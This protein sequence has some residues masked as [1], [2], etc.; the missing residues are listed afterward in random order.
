MA[1]WWWGNRKISFSSF[2]YVKLT[3]F[4]ICIHL[5]DLFTNNL[6]VC[7][8]RKGRHGLSYF[9]FVKNFG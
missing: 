9:V 7:F 1:E 6:G 8:V 3:T 5:N 4:V 2:F